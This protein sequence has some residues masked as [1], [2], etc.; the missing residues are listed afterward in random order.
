MKIEMRMIGN[1]VFKYG[2]KDQLKEISADRIPAEFK[3]LDGRAG[4]KYFTLDGVIVAYSAYDGNYAKFL[5]CIVDRSD[6]G[7]PSDWA[8][9]GEDYLLKSLWQEPK[10]LRKSL[11][12]METSLLIKM[13]MFLR[14]FTTM[15]V[16]SRKIFRDSSI[17]KKR[18]CT[19]TT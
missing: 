10:G 4:V 1:E 5:C 2:F 15:F 12:S 19:R 8:Y 13:V 9:T 14:D 11:G 16:V 18:K 17:K 7:Y 3:A 6:K